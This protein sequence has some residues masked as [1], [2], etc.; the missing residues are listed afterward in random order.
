MQL[1]GNPQ[2]LGTPI[3]MKTTP[4]C[5][6]LLPGCLVMSV[7]SE[8]PLSS[9]IQWWSRL[10]FCVVT[11]HWAG[12]GFLKKNFEIFYFVRVRARYKLSLVFRLSPVCSKFK[13]M[14]STGIQPFGLKTTSHG[15]PDVMNSFLMSDLPCEVV[16]RLKNWIL[17]G[18]L[19]LLQTGL[20]LK[21]RLSLYL[22]LTLK[23][24]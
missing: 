23:K 14:L 1:S 5:S 2:V 12:F 11:E 10:S 8:T 24:Y 18:N 7:K 13:F 15:K 6:A 16:F 20:S 17:V 9:D 22:A 4:R 19:N 21:T 3:M